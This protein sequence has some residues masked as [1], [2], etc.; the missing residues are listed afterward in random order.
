MKL[1][2]CTDTNISVENG[3]NNS[4]EQFSLRWYHLNYLTRTIKSHNQA[5]FPS[6][7]YQLHQMSTFFSWFWVF[8]PALCVTTYECPILTWPIR[9]RFNRKNL[10]S[11]PMFSIHCLSGWL[12][13]WTKT[14]VHFV[15]PDGIS[16]FMLSE[17]IHQVNLY[18][19]MRSCMHSA[20]QCPLNFQI[21]PE[22]SRQPVCFIIS[23][24]YLIIILRRRSQAEW[25]K[26][27]F[28]SKVRLWSKI[29]FKKDKII[30]HS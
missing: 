17:C 16:W 19:A 6:K 14:M 20:C 15:T 2:Y 10:L 8:Q 26:F 21:R 4:A 22:Q 18:L 25:R 23:S 9:A 7:G 29:N 13:T 5:T 11:S 24:H 3:P 28:C 12:P 30:C 1:L 27:T